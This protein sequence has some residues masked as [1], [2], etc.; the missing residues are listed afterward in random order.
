M[1]PIKR[2]LSVFKK[3]NF[4]R[5]PIAIKYLM[6]KPEGI[7]RIDRKIALCEML[8][9]AQKGTPFYITKDDFEC[10]GPFILGMVAPDDLFESGQVGYKLGIFEEPRANSRLYK[11]V[12]MMPKGTVRY[13]VF[14][15]YD[16]LTFNPDV[17][18]ITANPN[19]AEVVMRAL[20]YTTGKLWESKLTPVMGCAWMFV[21]PRVTGEVNYFVTNLVHGMRGR[22]VLPDGTFVISIPW[23]LISLIT[24][25]LN[26]ME[27]VL[28]EFTRDRDANARAFEK[29]VQEIIKELEE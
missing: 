22:Q 12:P 23:D 3:F 13:A 17:L 11:Y 5:P 16:K 26:H 7:N 9:E 25:N 20:V 6:K 15:P 27:W 4:E 10:V 24:E 1:D 18:V 2:D 14:A 28:P 29:E 8:G 21:Y 19:Q